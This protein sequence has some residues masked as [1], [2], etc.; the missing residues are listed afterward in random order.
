MATHSSIPAW[1]IPWTVEPGGLYSPWYCKKVRH[2]SAR[3][4]T[5]MHWIRQNLSIFGRKYWSLSSDLGWYM[6]LTMRYINS[7]LNVINLTNCDILNFKKQH[8]GSVQKTHTH[9]NR[10]IQ[11]IQT[12]RKI[13]NWKNK[14]KSGHKTRISVSQDHFI[15]NQKM[16]N[17]CCTL[18]LLN[19]QK[20]KCLKIPR[21]AKI[22]E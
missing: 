10:K 12:I 5:H 16:Q 8:K 13:Y 22:L 14:R 17:T 20:L 19:L 9:C 11:M 3:M 7:K 1:K 4:H 2:D 6:F 21:I 18:I 15:K